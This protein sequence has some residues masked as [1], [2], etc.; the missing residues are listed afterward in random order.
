MSRSAATKS[1]GKVTK[2]EGWEFLSA[3]LGSKGEAAAASAPWTSAPWTP[4]HSPADAVIICTG[5]NG[6]IFGKSTNSVVCTGSAQ[7]AL[8]QQGAFYANGEFIQVHPTAIP[9][10]DKLR[11][12]SESARGEGGRVWV[13]RDR[14]DKRVAN[15]RS[16]RPTATTSSKSATRSTATSYRATSPRARSS[17]SSTKTT[18][19]STASRW[20]TSTS[21]TCPKR[22]CNKLEG[23]LEIYEKFVGDDPREGPHEDLPRHA[24]HHGRPLG[25]LQPADQ[26]PRQ[27]S[28]RARP[29]TPST[30]PTASAQTRSSPASTEAYSSLA[31]NAIAS[32]R[33]RSSRAAR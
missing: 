14:N 16:P 24:L 13:P 31:R 9:G 27:S 2:Y 28:P 7:S 8:Y 23:I 19:A 3:V 25:R 26:H 32:T 5:G 18:W 22:G 29:T 33:R 10:E 1:E 15:V 30:A 6:A 12:M 11:L 17:R 20:S 21:H 4:A